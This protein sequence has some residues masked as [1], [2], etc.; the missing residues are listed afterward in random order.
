MLDGGRSSADVLGGK[1]TDK[2]VGELWQSAL[3]YPAVYPYVQALIR[4][5]VEER[6]AGIFW[7]KSVVNPKFSNLPDCQRQA[8]R[9]FGIDPATYKETT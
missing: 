6:A 5:L 7:S 4:K 9:D 2:E 3:R 1:M 8:L